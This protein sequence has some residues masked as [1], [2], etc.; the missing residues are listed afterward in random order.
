LHALGQGLVLGGQH[1]AQAHALVAQHVRVELGVRVGLRPR[2]RR[3]GSRSLRE[4]TRRDS[5]SSPGDVTSLPKGHDAWGVGDE[6]AIVDD[7]FG[8][9]HY[10]KE[11]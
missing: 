11:G 1:A 6:P 3:A 2:L 5:S 8:A 4:R 7:F 9:S 10:A